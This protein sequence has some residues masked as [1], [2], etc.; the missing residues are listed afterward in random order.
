MTKARELA[1]LGDVVTVDGDNIGLNQTSPSSYSSSG[2]N[3]VVGSSGSNGMTIVSGTSNSGNINFADGT[4]GS[5]RLRGYIQYQHNADQLVLGTNADDRVFID[6]SGNLLVG[7]TSTSLQQ[8]SSDEGFTYANNFTTVSRDGGTTAYFNRLTSDG[9]V[10]AFRKE[11]STVA[12][13][14]VTS[15]D[16]IYFAGAAG[17]TK[18]LLINDQGYI[19]SGYAGAASDNT[20]DIGNGT[21][22]YKQIYAAQ[23]S[24]NTSDANEKQQVASLT[25]TEMTA[26]KAISKLFKTFK[27]NDAVAA[28]GDAARTH[29]GVIAQNVQQAMT[30]AGLDAADYGFWCSDTWWETSTEVPA[31][32]ADE[33]NGIEAQEAYTRID[34]YDTEDAAPEG[35]TQRTRLGVRYPEL[36]AFIGAATEQRLANIETR[37]AAL[38]AE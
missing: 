7:T 31:V 1:E 29:A 22:R 6:S 2:D 17:S 27:W 20:V 11:G 34:T 19:P 33:E 38:E 18:G 14:G 9:D 13:I 15:S 23:G 12:T 37:L 32:E 30:D 21:Y 10:V 28:K 25:S 5:D 24:I 8:S 36:L 26:A 35:A 16:N 3:L 4:S